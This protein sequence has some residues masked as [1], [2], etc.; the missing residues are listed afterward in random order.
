VKAIVFFVIISS[1]LIMS[2]T[3]RNSDIGLA[4]FACSV[5]AALGA[6][7]MKLGLKKCN[8]R[9]K[10]FLLAMYGIRTWIDINCVLA[11]GIHTIAA[12]ILTDCAVS[13]EPRFGRV[14]QALSAFGEM[15]PSGISG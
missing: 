5:F 1:P 14:G 13:C 9:I 6:I 12:E 3:V 15:L 11:M 2:G 10:T 8:R 7:I 4:P